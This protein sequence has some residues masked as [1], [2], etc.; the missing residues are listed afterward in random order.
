MW[1]LGDLLTYVLTTTDNLSPVLGLYP[2]QRCFPGADEPLADLLRRT[3]SWVVGRRFSRVAVFDQDGGLK[4]TGGTQRV[5]AG[6]ETGSVGDL[7]R[8]VLQE[9]L[10]L[11]HSIVVDWTER[12]D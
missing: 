11:W 8:G 9:G 12:A 3:V 6:K 4:V 1:T 10:G 5:W 7:V 2:E